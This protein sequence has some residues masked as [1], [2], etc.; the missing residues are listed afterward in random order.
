VCL[1]YTA[2]AG[3]KYALNLIATPGHVDAR[4]KMT[5]SLPPAKGDCHRSIASQGVEAQTLAN[6]LHGRWRNN[7]EIIPVTQ[8]DFDFAKARAGRGAPESAIIA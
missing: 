8:Q 6:A 2:K 3:P 1:H 7:L 4:T 5:R